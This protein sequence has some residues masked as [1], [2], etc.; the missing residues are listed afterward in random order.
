MSHTEEE[1][2][3]LIADKLKKC[4][5]YPSVCQLIQ[6]ETGKDRVIT[7]IREIIFGGNPNIDSAIATVE[8]ELL[9]TE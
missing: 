2:N 6:T 5:E 3:L 7:R 1:L 9:F 4:S 8:T